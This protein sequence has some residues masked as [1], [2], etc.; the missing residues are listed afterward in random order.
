MGQRQNKERVDSVHLPVWSKNDPR[1][2]TLVHMQVCVG[3]LTVQSCFFFLF[4]LS[5]IETFELERVW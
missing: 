4:L 5:F 2:F 3:L 1:L